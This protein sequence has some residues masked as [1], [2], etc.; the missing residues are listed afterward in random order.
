MEFLNLFL[1]VK[2]HHIDGMFR[3]C[4]ILRNVVN[5]N[6]LC[7]HM[8]RIIGVC[9]CLLLTLSVIWIFLNWN[10]CN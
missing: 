5:I 2:F 10:C 7:P 9:N 4:L 6:L 8:L 3:M 1:Y